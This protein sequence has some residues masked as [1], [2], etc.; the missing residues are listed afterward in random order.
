MPQPT[1]GAVGA[2]PAIVTAESEVP[3]TPLDHVLAVYRKTTPQEKREAAAATSVA[4]AAGGFS[5]H[6]IAC[7]TCASMLSPLVRRLSCGCHDFG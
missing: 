1:S 5:A 7:G 3:L 2:G 6:E 4:T